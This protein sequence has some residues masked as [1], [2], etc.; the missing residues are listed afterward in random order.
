MLCLV[1]RYLT[2]NRKGYSL[3]GDFMLVVD[4]C[5]KCGKRKSKLVRTGAKTEKG[6]FEF[7]RGK[8]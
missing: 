3:S 7:Q 6:F 5:Q 2:A 4:V 8:T 1:H